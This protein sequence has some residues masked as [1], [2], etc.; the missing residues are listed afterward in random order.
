MQESTKDNS[1]DE[2]E[3]QTLTMISKWQVCWTVNE[4][5]IVVLG[6]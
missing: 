3:K 6:F 4:Y 1:E 5:H 2:Q